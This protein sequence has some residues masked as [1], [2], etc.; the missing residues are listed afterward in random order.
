MRRRSPVNS[1]TFVFADR[2]LIFIAARYCG[3]RERPVG[4]EQCWIGHCK[5]RIDIAFG[6]RCSSQQVCAPPRRYRSS[7]GSLLK[8]GEAN[9]TWP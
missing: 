6:H 9:R 5:F 2:N 3:R 7:G 1:T 8:R 4:L